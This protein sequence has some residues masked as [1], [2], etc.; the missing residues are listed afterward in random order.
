MQPYFIPY[1]GYWQ[2]MAQV[3]TYVVF[4]DVN[5]INRGWINRNRLI[6]PNGQAA[7]CNVPLK[8]VSQWNL[9][10]EIDVCR[11]SDIFE[12]NLRN[13]T[14][15][16]KKAPYYNEVF[17][18]FEKIVNN[19]SEKLIDYLMN[20]F[21][22]VRDYLGID[23]KLVMS[24]DIEKDPELKGQDKIL[25]IC[26]ALGATEY[27]NAIGGT[28]LYQ[29]EKF[30]NEG[31]TLRFLKT[32]DIVY[33]QGPNEF[34]PYLSIIDVMAWN[35]KEDIRNMLANFTLVEGLE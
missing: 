3:D 8:A 20:S 14:Q 34:I 26:K 25:A 16:Y 29:K 18:I 2:M 21:N 30:E 7:Y 24:S 10:N 12:K 4:D 15:V 22:L 6:A 17:P 31:I 9:I 33:S 28:E 35:S 11:P 5:Y 27:D 13:F 19:D 23:S 1:I 32:G